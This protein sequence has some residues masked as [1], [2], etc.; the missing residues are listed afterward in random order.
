MFLV[1]WVFF[2]RSDVKIAV[3]QCHNVT[4]SCVHNYFYFVLWSR[5]GGRNVQSYENSQFFRIFSSLDPFPQVF[6]QIKECFILE[7]HEMPR[8]PHVILFQLALW[9]M[10]ARRSART[11]KKWSFSG[12]LAVWV[13]FLKFLGSLGLRYIEIAWNDKINTFSCLRNT[14]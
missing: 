3:S 14:F 1:V 6:G 9:S 5:L 2:S 10:S 8:V 12:F 11:Y 13:L 7:L 4:C